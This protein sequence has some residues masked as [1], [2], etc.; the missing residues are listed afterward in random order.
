MQPN[1]CEFC[2]ANLK[3]ADT[4]DFII[5]LLHYSNICTWADIIGRPLNNLAE[6][7]I[8]FSLL[9]EYVCERVVSLIDT[10]DLKAWLLRKK[11]EGEWKEDE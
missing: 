10:E 2:G 5:R 6:G 7:R 4:N 3:G 9:D 8:L 1:K 11:I